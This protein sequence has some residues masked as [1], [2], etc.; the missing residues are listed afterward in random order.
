[1]WPYEDTRKP[2]FQL[3]I[4]YA[5]AHSMEYTCCYYK[6]PSYSSAQQGMPCHKKCIS[7]INM[8]SISSAQL[9]EEKCVV[10]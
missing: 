6:P 4:K 2:L 10:A 9:P 8:Y 5:F 3:Q 1:M 7:L